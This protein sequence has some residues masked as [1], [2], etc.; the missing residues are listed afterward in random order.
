MASHRQAVRAVALVVLG[1]SIGIPIRA[2][3]AGGGLGSVDVC[4][5]DHATYDQ[6]R[7]TLTEFSIDGVPQPM[8]D[9]GLEFGVSSDETSDTM[10][11]GLVPIGPDAGERDVYLKRVGP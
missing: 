10:F 11:A 8:P 5:G 4:G 2:W 6:A 3:S 1:M 9:G 7:M